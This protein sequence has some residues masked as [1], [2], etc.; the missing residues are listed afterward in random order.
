[1]RNL[2]IGCAR[3]PADTLVRDHRKAKDA[4]V[5]SS[6]A[7]HVQGLSCSYYLSGEAKDIEVG[8]ESVAIS[9]V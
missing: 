8:P 3:N 7:F 6:G 4:T 1:M 2:G 9:P 5:A